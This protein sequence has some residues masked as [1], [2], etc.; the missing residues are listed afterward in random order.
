M[1]YFALRGGRPEFLKKCWTKKLQ[2][3][4]RR[5]SFLSHCANKLLFF[6]DHLLHYTQIKHIKLSILAYIS[7]HRII[8]I[9]YIKNVLLHCHQIHYT[10]C[11]ITVYIS[12]YCFRLCGFCRL[13]SLILFYKDSVIYTIRRLPIAAKNYFLA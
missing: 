2:I 6:R 12:R 5:C 7:S 4:L 9:T 8:K 1:E 13:C 3:R 10:E 11:I